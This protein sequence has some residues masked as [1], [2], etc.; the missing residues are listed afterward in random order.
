MNLRNKI[1]LALLIIG[2]PLVTINAWW[3]AGQ[4]SR[5][6]QRV[7]DRLRQEA[8][9]AS[10]VVQVFLTDLADRG[11]QTALHMPGDARLQAY[12]KDRL[13]YLRFWNTGITGLAW[14]DAEGEILTGEPSNLFQRGV[15]FA[16]R[17]TLQALRTGKGWA[18]DDLVIEEDEGRALGI[19]RMVA[20][21]PGGTPRGL[22]GIRLRP[23]VF[24]PL[25]PLGRQWAQVRL[26]DQTGRLVYATDRADPT[27]DERYAWA[28]IPGLRET[29]N[30]AVATVRAGSLPGDHEGKEW[31]TA[32]VPIPG[33]GW[34]ASTLIPAADAMREARRALYGELAIQGVLLALCTGAALVLAHR[35]ALPARRLAEAARRIADGDRTARVG[36]TG[37]SELAAVGHAFDEMVE[38]LDSSWQ[39]L[40]A[41]RDAAEAMAARLA[42][43]SWLASLSSSTLDPSRVFDFIAEATSHL[44]DGAAVL[45][46]V[47]DA[48]GESLSLRASYAITR[49]ELRVQ[50]RFRAGEGLPGWVFQTREPLVL[51][52]ILEDA[53]ALNR[54]WAEAEG[55]RAFAGVPLLLRDRCLG[56]LYAA[57]GREQPFAAQDVDLLKSFA[58]HA[59]TAIQNA[60]LYERAESEAQRLRA[61]L[62]SMPAAVIVGEGR[63]EDRTIRLVMGNRAW[64]ELQESSEL[65]PGTRTLH[66]E[67]LHPDGSPLE[68][69]E[70]PLQRAIWR[71]E[72]T[73]EMELIMRLPGGRQRTLL[74]NAVPFPEIGGTR[75]AVGMMLDITERRQAEEELKRLAADNA[76]LYEQAAR[77]VQVKGLLLDELNHRVRNNLALMVSFMELQRATPAGRL[78]AQVLDD[79]IGRVKGLALIHNALGGTSFQAGQYETL[80]HRLAEQTFHQGPLAGRV[81]LRVEKEPLRLP[82]KALTALGIITNELFTNIAKHAFPEGR[83]G[84]VEVTVESAGS[85]VVIRIRD[86]GVRLPSGFSEGSGQLGLRLVRSLVE[87]SLQ[88]TFT[89]EAGEGTTAVIR[90]PRSEDETPGG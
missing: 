62:E 64:A 18:L 24:Q 59:A 8:Q 76:A 50:N 41:E 71:G 34:V 51:T 26:S 81:E 7:L 28:D 67:L 35:V 32:H 87:A 84:T 23:E 22:V 16:G 15:R 58:A 68:D 55:L 42:T 14:A 88:G 69:E 25:F 1:L 11:Q 13:A 49:P 83:N 43:L 39:A 52:N 38:V 31:M 53:R 56:V 57:R 5:E 10:R 6:R 17:E 45:L 80:V 2:L 4:Q 82:S 19:L 66:Y 9:E 40:K 48:E 75:Q 44:L 61:V 47:A 90:F 79:A 21:G 20:R 60:H 27:L 85:E 12:L 89:L 65:A 73:K 63:P 29:L 37:R 70:L 78:A 74:V 36:L 72:A 86:D 46:L 33:T 77:E 54:A 3:I 30:R